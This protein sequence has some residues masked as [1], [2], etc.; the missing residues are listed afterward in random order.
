MLLRDYLKQAFALE[1]GQK[2]YKIALSSG[3]TCPNRDGTLGT[4]GCIFCS[5]GGSGEFAQSAGQSVTQQIELGKSLIASKAPKG[6][7]SGYIAY[8]QSFTNTYAPA[9]RL[10]PLFTEAAVHPEVKVLSIAT[11]PDCLPDDVLDLLSELNRIK[12]VW[13]E[14]GLQTVHPE[15]AK[16]IRRGYDLDVFDSAVYELK[17]RGLSVIVHLILG[18]PGE[19]AEDMAE[20]CSYVS[21]K[22]LEASEYAPPA[23]VPYA[24]GVKLQLLHVLKGTD[25]A[26]EYAAGKF[27][28]LSMEEYF[29]ILEQC[30]KVTDEK[31]IIHRLT[32]DGAKRDL[33]APLWSADKKKVLN[34]W[35]KRNR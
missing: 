26:D 1:E 5:A 28:T 17:K 24:D 29:D 20:S 11:R 21:R 2:L 14:L 16:Y 34:A 13:V 12:P 9:E 4:G 31:L 27:K 18:L 10:R 7:Y 35:N 32:G 3:C 19:S 8:F 25:L 33:I 30:L 15:T 6:G 23:A 22:L